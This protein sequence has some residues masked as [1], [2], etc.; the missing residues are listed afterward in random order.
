MSSARTM[1]SSVLCFSFNFFFSFATI[2][3]LVFLFFLVEE[4]EIYLGAREWTKQWWKTRN[5][6]LFFIMLCAISRRLRSGF[7]PLHCRWARL[8]A[9]PCE[10]ARASGVSGLINIDPVFAFARLWFSRTISSGKKNIQLSA[11]AN[12]SSKSSD[13]ER[14]W[15]KKVTATRAW[16]REEKEF[17]ER[18]ETSGET[19]AC[20]AMLLFCLFFLLYV[21]FSL[22]VYDLF[23]KHLEQC[24]AYTS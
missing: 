20:C 2:M 1:S 13:D 17:S 8:V 15:Q 14:K 24:A 23:M 7:F 12:S 4:L 21:P 6:E 22:P 11:T 16:R 10:R 9:S 19:I 3:I 5:W 18:N